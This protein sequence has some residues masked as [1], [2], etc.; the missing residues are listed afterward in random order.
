MGFVWRDRIGRGSRAAPDAPMTGQARA[1]SSRSKAARASASRSRPSGSRS[2]SRRLGSPSFA[3]AS[4]EGRRAPRRCVRRFSRA[5][6]ADLAPQG[7][8]CCS[9]PRASTISTRR[10]CR[11]SRAE[12]GSFPTGSP[13][14]TRAYQGAAGNLPPDFIAS[15]ERLTVGAN[16]PDLTLIL[17]L[18]PE[19]GLRRATRAK[20]GGACRP[21]RIGGAAISSNATAGV[22]RHRRGRASRCAVIDA[23]GTEG[24]GR[25]RH[26]VGGREQARSRERAQG[27]ARMRTANPPVP[28]RVP[29]G[30]ARKR[31]RLEGRSMRTDGVMSWSMLRDAAL[32]RAS[33]A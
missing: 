23:D 31:R 26:L 15:L 2:A 27:E 29:R 1:G 6:R 24:R 22:P 33:S 28:T 19:V 10:F 5:S 25:R 4:P 16:R 18:D 30:R 21:V 9:P 8:R 14:S 7:R 13:N 11:R 20:A 32:S 17:D 3:R 12:P